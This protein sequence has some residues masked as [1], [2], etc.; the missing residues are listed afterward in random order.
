MSSRFGFWL[1]V[2]GAAVMIFLAESA[3][4]RGVESMDAAVFMAAVGG[5]FTFALVILAIPMF[6]GATSG[7]ALLAGCAC[8]AMPLV[9]EWALRINGTQLNVHGVAILGFFLYAL[10]SWCCAIGLLIATA[11]RAIARSRRKLI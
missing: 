5:I 4:Y 3:E 7:R 11:V 6:R 8:G 1:A 2:F 9:I 10:G